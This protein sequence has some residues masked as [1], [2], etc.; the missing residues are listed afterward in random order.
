MVIPN[1]LQQPG[2][3]GTAYAVA[4]GM[5]PNVRLQ[6]GIAICCEWCRLHA[7]PMLPS[8]LA[9]N[10]RPPYDHLT[11]RAR[12]LNA[13]TTTALDKCVQSDD[14]AKRYPTLAPSE[15]HMQCPYTPAF[16]ASLPPAS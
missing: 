6:I 1:I 8:V 10:E 15:P 13:R 5:V 16:S 4:T 12:W 14:L 9:M 3:E 11:V 2:V 7:M